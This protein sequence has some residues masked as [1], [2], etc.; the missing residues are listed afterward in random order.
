MSANNVIASPSSATIATGGSQSFSFSYT[1]DNFTYSAHNVPSEYSTIQSA[2]D[3]ASATSFLENMDL[4]ID[5]PYTTHVL[6]TEYGHTGSGDTILVAPGTY[7][8]N[9]II[10]KSIYLISTDGDPVSTIIDGN[11]NNAHAIKVSLGGSNSFYLNGFTIQ[12]GGNGDNRI[13]AGIFI[14]DDGTVNIVNNIINAGTGHGAGLYSRHATGEVTRNIFINNTANWGS[15]VRLNHG[16]INFYN[17]T[18]WNNHKYSSVLR[19]NSL[20]HRIVNNII[21]DD[22]PDD[23]FQY[24]RYNYGVL[25]EYNIVVN[26]PEYGTGNISDNPLLSD[27]DNGDFRL[28]EFSPAIDAGD[29]D[30]DDD[31]WDWAMD[32]DDRDVDG[33]RM[34]IG[35]RAFLPDSMN[36][37]TLADDWSLVTSFSSEEVDEIFSQISHNGRT[38]IGGM[39]LDRDGLKEIIL[40]DYVGHRVIVF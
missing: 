1:A 22:N 10:D 14:E 3:A 4:T 12:N 16:G 40:T 19:I 5:D 25:I 2:V 9:V 15:A 26:G 31:G 28:T 7:T 17:N 39:D 35:Q 34:D 33:T 38:V 27:P 11:N 13:G 18:L 29:P 21:W 32:A 24:I 8:E 6:I 23:N 20:D 36:N 30:L 37:Y